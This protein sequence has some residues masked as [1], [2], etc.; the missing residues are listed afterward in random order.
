MAPTFKEGSRY[1]SDRCL[2]QKSSDERTLFDFPSPIND[3]FKSFHKK[4]EINYSTR[5]D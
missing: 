1:A 5:I 3:C 4:R 2:A